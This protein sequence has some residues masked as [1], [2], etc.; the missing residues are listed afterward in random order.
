MLEEQISYTIK[1]FVVR[2][3]ASSKFLSMGREGS[4][5]VTISD[6]GEVQEPEDDC[7]DPN[8]EISNA[9]IVGVC[10]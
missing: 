7:D 10:N 4:E 2:E 3:Y 8:K 5:I 6:I 1:Y 9:Q